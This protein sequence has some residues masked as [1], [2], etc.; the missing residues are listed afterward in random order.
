MRNKRKVIIVANSDHVFDINNHIQEKDLIVRFN[1]PKISSLKPTATRTDFLF[2][3][4]SVD[5]VQKKLRNNSKF[6]R[7]LSTIDNKFTVVFPYSDELIKMNKPQYKKK[8]FIFFRK[9]TNNFN[10]S[11]YIS[12]LNQL[13]FNVHVLADHKRNNQ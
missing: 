2:L 8:I 4:N 11:Q 12:F 10:N 1:I 6:I 3:A 9:L 13:G 7:F 5:V